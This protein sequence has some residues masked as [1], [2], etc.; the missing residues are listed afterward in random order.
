MKVMEVKMKKIALVFPGQGSQYIGMGKI[1]CK[2]AVEADKVFEEANYTLGF[3]LKKLCFEGDFEELTKTE[4]TQPAILSASVAAYKLYVKEVGIEPL[5]AAGHSLGEISALTCSGAIKFSDALKIVRKRGMLMKSAVAPG[6]GAMSAVSGISIDIIEEECRKFS[7]RDSVVSISNYN[8]LKQVVISG[9]KNAVI[10]LGER[11]KGLGASVIALKV[12]APF[13]CSLMEPISREFRE[14]L[15]K[16]D[17]NGLKW[18]VISNVTALPYTGT[19]QIIDNLTHQIYKPVRWQETMD[20]LKGKGV[21]TI[22]ELGPKS[23]LKN[24][25]IKGMEGISAYSFDL[26]DDVKAL[27]ELLKGQKQAEKESTSNYYKLITRTMAIAV[28]TKNSNWN[29]EE[30]QKGVVE[31]YR[32]IKNMCEELDREN[33]QPTFE[34]MKEAVHML[35][36]VFNTKGTP[37]DEQIERFNHIFSETLTWDLVP[38]FNIPGFPVKMTDKQ[39]INV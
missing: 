18:P 16:Y 4:N 21:N 37:M 34:Q 13:H 39:T 33:R 29:S 32:K 31:P 1:L 9:H 6:I 12:S 35:V 10:E 36:S 26:E 20:Y 23:V 17:F 5:Y 11:L 19:E 8:S 30:Y 2:K 38:D 22:I 7:E 25:A 14:E 24:L 3:D 27:D 15:G 28:C